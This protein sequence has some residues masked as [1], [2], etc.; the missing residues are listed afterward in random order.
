MI[1]VAVAGPS[2]AFSCSGWSRGF[3]LVLVIAAENAP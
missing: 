1:A 3:V 2:P